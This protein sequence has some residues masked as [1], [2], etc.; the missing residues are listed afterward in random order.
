MNKMLTYFAPLSLC[1]FLS[2]PFQTHAQTFLTNGLLA[3]YPFNGNANDISGNANSAKPAGNF[4][5]VPNGIGRMAFRAI[6]DNS[7]FYSSGGNVLLPTFTT[8]LNSGFTL[9]VWVKD[10]IPG[11]DVSAEE[12]YISFGAADLSRLEISLHA[13]SQQVIYDMTIGAGPTLAEFDMPVDLPSY[14]VAGW[15]QLILAYQPGSFACYFN[16]QKL[17]QTN[18]TVNVFPV[19]QA[20]LNRHWWDNGISSAARMSATYQN[21]RVYNRA[22]SD[23]EVQQLYAIEQP[24][25]IG[26][27]QAVKP[28]FSF[29]SVGTNY[30]LQVSSDLNN[31]TNQGSAFMATNSNMIYPQY[32]DVNNWG[33]LFFRLQATP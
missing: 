20:A 19:A 33:N 1:L 13:D 4:Q 27:I 30:Q 17:Y 10:E 5:F 6:G 21:V 24:P 14:T 31:W 15:K 25:L 32:F 12:D 3:Y 23:G 22:L 11:S 8:N 18:V 7:L 26:L 2:L 9:S 16:G 28:S 29:L